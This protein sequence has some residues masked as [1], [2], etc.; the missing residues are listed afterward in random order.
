MAI[1][2]KTKSR[3]RRV[4]AVPPRPPVYVRK[5]PLFRRRWFLATVGAVAVAGILTGVLVHLSNN[6]RN[7]LHARTL[8][9]VTKF[10]GQVKGLFPPPPDSQALPPTGFEVYP[11]LS[12]DLDSVAKGDKSVNGVDKGNS[13]MSSAKASADAIAKLS[14]SN[15][16][17][18]EANISEG[19]GLKGPGA[20]RLVMI[21]AQFLLQQAFLTYSNVG[22][23]MAQAG[24]LQG[25]ART[26][27]ITRAKALVTTAQTLFSRGYEKMTT[28]QSYLAP[29]PPNPFPNS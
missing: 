7:A 22:G 12:S 4:V 8:G 29:L 2:G 6:H 20:T 23:L 18:E 21:D 14:V 13:L 11:T 28:I 26:D 3:S 16:I 1:K 9:A 19:P 17:P 24:A 15:L 5:K 25:T 10:V 27:L